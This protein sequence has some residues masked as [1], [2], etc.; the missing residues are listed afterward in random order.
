MSKTLETCPLSCPEGGEGKTYRFK[1]KYKD[2][3]K[4]SRGGDN[5]LLL[6]LS[7][8]K[9][10]HQKNQ[11][12]IN[13]KI[14]SLGVTSINFDELLCW[15]GVCPLAVNGRFLYYDH[16]HLSVDGALFIY[17]ALERALQP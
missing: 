7:V 12:L 4:K 10:E 16:D 2:A 13:Q 8:P 11:A 9:D 3:L 5:K 6:Q 17:P 14:S 1:Y 15:G